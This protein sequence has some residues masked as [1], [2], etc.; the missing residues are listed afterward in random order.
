M[1]PVVTQKQFHTL[2]SFALLSR[3]NLHSAAIAMIQRKVQQQEW[4]CINLR[5]P[6][7]EVVVWVAIESSSRQF[8]TLLALPASWVTN[9]THPGSP[10]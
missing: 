6:S 9:V 1:I 8:L 4:S 10:E 5:A 7:N 2:D 3:C